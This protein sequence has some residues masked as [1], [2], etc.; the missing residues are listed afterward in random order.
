MQ[1]LHLFKEALEIR[2]AG[3]VAA[4]TS[5]PPVA[6]KWMHFLQQDV[7]GSF[8]RAIGQ[9]ERG[10]SSEE[11]SRARCTDAGLS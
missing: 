9:G 11:V 8:I 7:D 1:L 6:S 2:L 5:E 4:V 10:S 3:Y